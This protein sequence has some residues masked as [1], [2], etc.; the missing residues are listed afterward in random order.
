MPKFKKHHYIAS[1]VL[2]MLIAGAVLVFRSPDVQADT[3]IFSDTF[4]TNGAT[5]PGWTEVET[6]TATT[7]VA[8]NKLTFSATADNVNRPL[9]KRTFTSQHSGILRWEY[10]FD[11]DRTGTEGIYEVHMQIGDNMQ[12]SNWSSGVA[13]DLVW[14]RWNTSMPHETLATMSSGATTT[15]M[16]FLGDSTAAVQHITVD[17]NIVAKTYSVTVAT[18]TSTTFSNIPFR[19]S[20]VSEISQVRFF[21]NGLNNIGLGWSNRSIDNVTVTMIDPCDTSFPVN[22]FHGCFYDAVSASALNAMTLPALQSP[23][24]FL[25]EHSTTTIPSP[26]G[27]LYPAYSMNW[28][29]SPGN[30]TPAATSSYVYA[31][32]RGRINFSPGSYVFRT[33]SDDGVSVF[34]DGVNKISDWTQ[35]GPQDRFS[36]TTTLTGASNI[37]LWYREDWGGA[38]L[39][40]GW[41]RYD[42]CSDGVDNDGDGMTDMADYGCGISTDNDEYNPLPAPTQ[43]TVGS[44]VKA[45]GT[46]N[47]RLYPGGPSSDQQ[48]LNA[49]GTVLGGPKW[50][51]VGATPYWYWNVDFDAGADGWATD[52]L[53]D[54]VTS[55]GVVA[56]DYFFESPYGQ[57]HTFT[58][59]SSFAN[60]FSVAPFTVPGGH[61]D[62]LMIVAV[63]GERASS[64]GCAV[65][66]VAY[67]VQEM[68][69]YISTTTLSTSVRN[70]CISLWYLDSPTVGTNNVAITWSSTG[71]NVR[72]R[73]VS[74]MLLSGVAN[75]PNAGVVPNACWSGSCSIADATINVTQ[76]GSIVLDAFV[77]GTTT[78]STSVGAGQTQVHQAT[79]DGPYDLRF[80]ASWEAAPSAGNVTMS[81]T[82][83]TFN[84]SAHVA[85][86]VPPASFSA[87]L[88]ICSDGI[89][90]DAD[91]RIDYGA[92]ASNDPGCSSGSDTNE[93]SQCGDGNDNDGDTYIDLNDTGCSGLWD[94]NE[95]STSQC[96]DGADNDGDSLID[97]GADPGCIS[98]DDTNETD[99]SLAQ[100]ADGIDNDGDGYIDIGEPGC[101]SAS[102]DSEYNRV[103]RLY[104]LNQRVIVVPPNPIFSAVVNFAGGCS[105]NASGFGECFGNPYPEQPGNNEKGSIANSTPIFWDSKSSGQYGRGAWY[106]STDLDSASFLDGYLVEDGIRAASQCE[107][108]LDNDGTGGTDLADSDCSSSADQSESNPTH[109]LTGWAWSAWEDQ[110]GKA[111]GIGW[112]SFSNPDGAGIDY[113]VDVGVDG[114]LSGY[115]WSGGGRGTSTTPDLGT[116]IGWISFNKADLGGC[117]KAPC[118]AHL[119]TTT[120]KVTGW[121]RACVGT[122]TTSN[123]IAGTCATPA[124]R[125]DGWD[126]WISLSK[127]ANESIEYGVTVSGCNYSGWAWGGDVIGWISFS[128]NQ[129]STLQYGVTGVG[130]GCQSPDSNLVACDWV[131]DPAN[132]QYVVDLAALT[133]EA[134]NKNLM[135]SRTSDRFLNSRYISTT[136]GSYVTAATTS[137]YAFSSAV[138]PGY[139]DI[140][141]AVYDDHTVTETSEPNESAYINLFASGQSTPTAQS[142]S[143]FDLQDTTPWLYKIVSKVDQNKYISDAI[144]DLQ[145][146][147]ASYPSGGFETTGDNDFWVLCALLREVG[148]SFELKLS[149]NPSVETSLAVVKPAD[150]T[151]GSWKSNP[152]QLSV[153]RN[154]GF[155]GN[156]TLMVDSIYVKCVDNEEWCTDA[157][158]DTLVSGTDYTA[159]FANG[160]LSGATLNDTLTLT[161]LN[162]VLPGKYGVK[163]KGWDSSGCGSPASCPNQ[164][165]ITIDLDIRPD[166]I[167]TPR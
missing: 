95:T 40:F 78:V 3:A 11:F 66:R 22:T 166:N 114:E 161:I 80:G 61:S 111:Q 156:I 31:I 42:A 75:A 159:S 110:D 133:G 33:N 65:Q 48:F 92:G 154:G 58:A 46:I 106:W 27:T 14:G 165:T 121:A 62:T 140:W 18:T 108:G 47:I 107:D 23:E 49:T 134:G 138:P 17:V 86:S 21:Y 94:N 20:A 155:T 122:Y 38:V 4:G 130:D 147:H 123:S 41:T 71:Y 148:P 152:L 135:L 91:G 160:V 50:A 13:A 73:G 81:W 2:L 149:A 37:E 144:T 57:A 63:Y 16:D 8:N 100:C 97:F 84:T 90:N 109:E 45:M 151:V 103:S 5:V 44:R 113:G 120:G 136:P 126:G 115:A 124:S 131:N 68:I 10:D 77:V 64:A 127:Q 116:G 76:P 118:E 39:N 79:S 43:F 129:Y 146:V 1:L 162:D 104:S 88:D 82:G 85:I 30:I 25:A 167:Y 59:T 32:Y 98:A 157:E 137:K 142:S 69:P 139:Y 117:P 89:D 36:A 7:S 19:D 164:D 35:H 56:S 72:D 87:G 132:G 96:S 163:L 143:I 145:F 105:I 158:G 52:S 60:D 93:I 26:V 15:R 153:Q 83:T 74:M 112:I 12:D 102:D 70:N 150:G 55:L 34:I 6:G 141:L 9:V 125:S 101:T 51:L 24:R 99:A 28:G 119:A 53:L 67:G 128:G 54:P 29:T